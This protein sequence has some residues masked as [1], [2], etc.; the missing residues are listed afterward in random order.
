MT[1]E[2]LKYAE[3]ILPLKLKMEVSYIIP[4]NL[5]P[6]INIGSRVRVEMGGREYIAVVRNISSNCGEYAGKIK[7]VTGVEPA[8]AITEKEFE[9]WEWMASYYMCTIGEVYRA[10]FTSSITEQEH[11][12]ARNRPSKIKAGEEF[13]KLSAAQEKA[14]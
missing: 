2:N 9:F 12:K 4:E 13:S 5:E 11:K 1:G 6:E 10:A 7:E 14:F 8:P 3:V